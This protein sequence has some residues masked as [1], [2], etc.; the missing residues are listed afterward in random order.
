MKKHE[1][2]VE[3]CFSHFPAYYGELFSTNQEAAF[4]NYRFWTSMGFVI[5]FVCSNMMCLDTKLYILIG[6][7]LT[8]F[9][10]YVVVEVVLKQG[11]PIPAELSH[12][13]SQSET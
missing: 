4:S 1:K 13:P 2:L 6:T 11:E 9:V 10:L 7:L 12:S 5:S 8:G 3:D